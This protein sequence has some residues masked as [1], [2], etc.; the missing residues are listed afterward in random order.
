[1]DFDGFIKH[2][3][4]VPRRA[5]SSVR[6]ATLDQTRLLL[7]DFQKRSPLDSGHFKS[8]WHIS[9][10]GGGIDITYS[11]RNNTPYSIPLDEG[12]AKGAPP[13][14]FPGKGQKR[15]GGTISKSGKLIVR[16][17]RV[18]AGGLSPEGHVVG[19]ITGKIVMNN[20]KRQKSIAI[21]IADSIIR[22]I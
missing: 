7:Q 10:V 15:R 16:N 22:V 1:M 4:T 19:G 20:K 18:W 5:K 2:L 17:N 14:R 11:I 12:V 9:N 6:V 8:Q 3:T 13:W 21:A